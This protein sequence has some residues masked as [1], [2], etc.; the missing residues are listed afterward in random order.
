MST[1]DLFPDRFGLLTGAAEADA[2]RSA[3]DRS[4]VQVD[5]VDLD[6]AETEANWRELYEV[7]DGAVLVRPDGHVGWRSRCA[8]DDPERALGEALDA[9]LA[10]SPPKPSSPFT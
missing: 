3:A 2:W 5:V 10:K 6:A 7:E 8:V 1:L 4:A 9:L